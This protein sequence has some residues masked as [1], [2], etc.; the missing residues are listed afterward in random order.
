[1]LTLKLYSDS[2]LIKSFPYWLI[3]FLFYSC[4][5]NVIITMMNILRIKVF[6]TL[7]TFAKS[8]SRKVVV[9][10]IPSCMCS[11]DGLS[12]LVLWNSCPGSDAQTFDGASDV[13]LVKVISSISAT[14]IC[15]VCCYFLQPKE[16]VIC[17]LCR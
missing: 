2:A 3:M 14:E 17:F 4:R 7:N 5:Y 12:G 8:L 13:F 15:G 1:M 10:C 6:K 9:V 16:Y 11:H